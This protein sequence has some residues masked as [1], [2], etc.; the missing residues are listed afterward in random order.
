MTVG[1][2]SV[3]HFNPDQYP[4]DAAQAEAGSRSGNCMTA[5]LGIGL[6]K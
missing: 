2:A 4:F 3:P 6:A 1:G 5:S